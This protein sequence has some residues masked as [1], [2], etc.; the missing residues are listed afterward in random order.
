MLKHY[1]FMVEF[2]GNSLGKDVEINLYSFLKNEEGKLVAKTLNCNEKL[3]SSIPNMYLKIIKKYKN[4]KGNVINKI[5]GKDKN[6]KLCRISTYFIEDK[7]KEKIIGILNIKID[8]SE[9]ISAANYLNETLKSITGGPERNLT[10][11]YEEETFRITV[12]EYSEKMINKMFSEIKKPNDA[13]TTS[14]KIRI[15]KR[16]DE[17]G[18]FNLKGNIGELAKRFNTSEK[19]IYR[20]LKSEN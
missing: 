9:I 6:G 14:E 2:L 15:V 19:T 17:K 13:L 1:K 10:Q 18:V 8:I 5:P 16:L 20:Y 11:E 12:E 4:I 7:L 3:G